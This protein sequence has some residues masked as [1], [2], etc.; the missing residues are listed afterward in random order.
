VK[1]QQQKT[2]SMGWKLPKQGVDLAVCS[3]GYAVICRCTLAAV[4]LVWSALAQILRKAAAAPD[5]ATLPPDTTQCVVRLNLSITVSLDMSGA[6][7]NSYLQL[8]AEQLGIG[9]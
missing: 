8:N 6:A 1:A 2:Q 4:L 7:D 3:P 5:F 9:C